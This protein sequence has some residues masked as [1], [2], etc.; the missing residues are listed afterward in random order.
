MRNT[1][2]LP[3]AFTA[4][5]SGLEAKTKD[6]DGCQ[7]NCT[8]SPPQSFPRAPASRESVVPAAMFERLSS[9]MGSCHRPYRISMRPFGQSPSGRLEGDGDIRPQM[10][11]PPKKSGTKTRSAP[12]AVSLRPFV[13]DAAL[14]TPEVGNRVLAKLRTG[15]R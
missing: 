13:E 8:A 2:S 10:F 7:E 1:P 3:I 5:S 12:R 9:S 6:R 15:R 14:A 4:F 11:H